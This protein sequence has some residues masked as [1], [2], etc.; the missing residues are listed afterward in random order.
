MARLSSS[1]VILL[2]VILFVRVTGINANQRTYMVSADLGASWKNIAP[3]VWD[4]A[5]SG[6]GMRFATKI[7]WHV[8]SAFNRATALNVSNY[9][10]PESNWACEF[11]FLF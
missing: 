10:H 9:Y 11:H 4:A 7:P 2:H 5:A 3:S 8:T 6:T 1:E